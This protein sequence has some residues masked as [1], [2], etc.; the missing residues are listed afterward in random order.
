[1]CQTRRSTGQ[2]SSREAAYLGVVEEGGRTPG[3]RASWPADAFLVRPS[4]SA[5]LQSFFN[6]SR[7]RPSLK[8]T[9]RSL[10]NINNRRRTTR[11]LSACD[12][13]DSAPPTDVDSS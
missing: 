8:S 13:V 9:G 5:P 4:R 2:N 3:R 12:E 6:F 11:E 10:F 1:M 7:D